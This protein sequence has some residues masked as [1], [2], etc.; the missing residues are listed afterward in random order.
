MI[1]TAK[2]AISTLRHLVFSNLCKELRTDFL[3]INLV[4]KENNEG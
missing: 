4:E 2:E 3:F 1:K